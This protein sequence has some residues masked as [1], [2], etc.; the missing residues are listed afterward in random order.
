MVL[1][2]CPVPPSAF[3]F[4]MLPGDDEADNYNRLYFHQDVPLHFFSSNAESYRAFVE[5]GAVWQDI[6]KMT[7][8]DEVAKHGAT[9][10]ALAPELYRDL[11]ASLNMTVNTTQ[12]PGDRCYAHRVEGSDA[13]TDGQMGA[14][15][16]SC[17]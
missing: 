1:A 2:T 6:G 8:R 15:Y 17:E 7:G 12:S 4:G 13:L 10:L 3:R 9:L 5:M 11:H 16:R 14:A